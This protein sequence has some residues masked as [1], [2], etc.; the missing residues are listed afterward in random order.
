MDL[1]QARQEQIINSRDK[2]AEVPL[3]AQAQSGDTPESP[4]TQSKNVDL[5]LRKINS[6][7][8]ALDLVCSITNSSSTSRHFSILLQLLPVLTQAQYIP[9][10]DVRV[11]S[12]Y[13][14]SNLAFVL[15]VG[16]LQ[17]PEHDTIL[18]AHPSSVLSGAVQI[19]QLLDFASVLLGSHENISWMNRHMVLTLLQPLVFR[20]RFQLTDVSWTR[21]FESLLESLADPTLEVREQASVTL[22]GY[23][24]VLEAEDKLEE[25]LSRFRRLISTPVPK[26]GRSWNPAHPDFPTA[27]QRVQTGILGLGAII[28][29]FPHDVPTFVPR[30]LCEIVRHIND[31]SPIPLSVKSILEDFWRTHQDMWTVH[32]REFTADELDLLTE[33]MIAPYYYC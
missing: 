29:A 22:S 2:G 25:L 5:A 14:S 1:V 7:K 18:N 20:N 4:A 30:T 13:M 11:S 8:T 33:Q 28:R 15:F 27:L 10:D 17:A 9:D 19:P 6:L 16:P 12:Y 32:K 23:I 31:P 21:F 24:P 3:W 26:Q